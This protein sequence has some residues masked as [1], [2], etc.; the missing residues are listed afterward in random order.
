MVQ[1]ACTDIA[2]CRRALE[3]FMQI[4]LRNAYLVAALAIVLLTVNASADQRGD[5]DAK[6]AARAAFDQGIAHGKQGRH[7]EAE[8]AFREAVRLNP[9]NATYYRVL[10]VALAY[11]KQWE[12]AAVA[13]RKALQVDPELA[14]AH[15]NLGAALVNLN[16]PKEA[17]RAFE[18]AVRLNPDDRNAA[19]L[20][21]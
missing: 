4:L 9:N 19:R 10:G 7:E 21:R 20:I 16:Q 15:H 5:V 14:D 8:S 12:D 17:I 3:G 11:L 2:I 13:Y 18:N 1:D 6:G